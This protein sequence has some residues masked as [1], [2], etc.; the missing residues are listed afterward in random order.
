[1]PLSQVERFDAPTIGAFERELE[2]QEARVLKRML[3]EY[4]AAAGKLFQIET[5][6]APWAKSI[7]FTQIDGVGGFELDDGQTTNLPFVEMAGEE[8]LLR[9]YRYR[10]GYYFD[11]EEV[12]A[13]VHRGVNIEEQK[14]ALV[15]Q[16]YT[17]TMNRLL[18]FGDKKTGNA[19][20]FNHPAWLRSV[21]PYKL[22]GSVSNPNLILATLNAGVQ[23]IKK[24]T[25]K[26]VK[27]DTLLLPEDRFDRLMS[28]ERINDFQE[29]SV[30]RY[31]IEN[32]PSIT[33]VQPMPELE[34]AG[35]NG[36]HIAIFYK[37]DPLCFKACITDAFRPR[38]LI[39]KDPFKVYRAYAFKFAGLKVYVRY[40][41]H[42][43]IGV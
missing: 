25:D 28:Q 39:Q 23:G 40:S 16:A 3:P 26:I 18:L 20:F 8:Y 34:K 11:E 31:F 17:E 1:M 19:G 7:S 9:P 10:S 30:L 12:S 29:K 6:K 22:D 33:Q 37:R 24:A 27:P 5:T 21:A 4:P 43:M 36:E 32:N 2:L 35:P 42:V 15:Q 13:T 41:A 14:I 38:P